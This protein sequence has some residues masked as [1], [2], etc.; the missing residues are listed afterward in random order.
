MTESTPPPRDLVFPPEYPELIARVATKWSS[1]E[2]AINQ[3]I[4]G[5][6]DTPQAFG[7]CIT[8]QLTS[9]HTRLSALLALM[10]V[11]G[12]SKKLIDMN[13]FADNVRGAQETR[14]RIIHD[15]WLN[16]AEWPGTM[17]RLEIIAPKKLTIAIRAINITELRQDF[18]K[19]KS[20]T[21]DFYTIKDAILAELP[22]LPDRHETELNPIETRRPA[23]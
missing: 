4:W 3:T 16:S 11:R 8:S 18:E 19:I 1:L 2:Y 6:A 15:P 20:T 9:L 13:E 12:S 14:N 10:R 5:L 21:D 7:A 17:G 22:S 23:R